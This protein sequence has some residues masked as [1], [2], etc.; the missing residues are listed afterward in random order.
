MTSTT[1][2][3]A[4]TVRLVCGPTA[5]IDDVVAAFARRGWSDRLC[6]LAP[7]GAAAR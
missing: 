2:R 5:V 7:G 3:V 4:V 1:R 6:L